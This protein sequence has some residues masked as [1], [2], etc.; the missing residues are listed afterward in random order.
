MPPSRSGR[1]LATRTPRRSATRRGGRRSP[2][3]GPGRTLLAVALGGS[4][5]FVVW[6]LVARDAT[7]IPTLAAGLAVYGLVFSALAIAGL[8]ATLRAARAGEGGRAFAAALL[9]GL[10]LVVA[11]GSFGLAIVLSLLL[12]AG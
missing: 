2:L 9:G 11:A 6:G 7:Q 5:L 8:S 4:T 1:P 10:A 12:G 3:A